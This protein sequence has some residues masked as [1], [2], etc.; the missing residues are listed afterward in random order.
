MKANPGN[1]LP[2]HFTIRKAKTGMAHVGQI[3]RLQT[4]VAEGYVGLHCLLVPLV[5]EVRVCPSTGPF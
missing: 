2:V 4:D 3:P 1:K 5:Q